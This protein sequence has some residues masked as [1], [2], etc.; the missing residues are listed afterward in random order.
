VSDTEIRRDERLGRALRGLPVAE[1]ADGFWVDLDESLLEDR[2]ARRAALAV[3]GGASDE[4]QGADGAGGVPS[5]GLAGPPPVTR[6]RSRAKTQDPSSIVLELARHAGDLTPHRRYRLPSYSRPYSRRP[7]SRRVGIGLALVL[8]AIVAIVAVAFF[9]RREANEQAAESSEASETIALVSQAMAAPTSLSGGLTVTEFPVQ[10]GVP[11]PVGRVYT[12]VWR[13]DGS[14]RYTAADTTFDEG[15]DAGIGTRRTVQFAPGFGAVAT[16]S[17]NVAPGP[18]DGVSP[19]LPLAT[20]IQSVF[21]AV[22]ANPTA[23]TVVEEIRDGNPVIVVDTPITPPS[24]PGPNRSR[25]AVDPDTYLPVAVSQFRDDQPWE[26]TRI[27]NLS[28]DAPLGAENFAVPLPA[29]AQVT[30]ADGGFRRV[31]SPAEATAAVGYAASVPADI[32]E[33]FKL[34]EVAVSGQAQSPGAVNADGSQAPAQTAQGIV[35]LSYRRGFEQLV[36]TT[37]RGVTPPSPDW[38]DPFGTPP[39]GAGR[40]I[41]L[42]TGR[43][44]GVTVESVQAVPAIPHLWGSTDELVFTVGGILGADELVR[45]AESLD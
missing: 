44:E 40:P 4:A 24:D 18:P 39:G 1:H 45:V 34:A 13:I 16:E 42:D 6:I 12:F 35:L 11:E 2:R 29:G 41:E 20:L 43:F 31:A 25:L 8:T 32:P 3:A 33:G 26:D 23:A 5:A 7:R 37:R 14:Y 15:Y 19:G 9:V 10:T 17:T 36:V 30:P 27:D 28:V 38:T 21:R 22:L